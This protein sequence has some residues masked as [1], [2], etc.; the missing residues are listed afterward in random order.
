[1]AVLTVIYTLL[2]CSLG[3]FYFTQKY[4][5]TAVPFLGASWELVCLPTG[6]S[7]WGA[8][9]TFAEGMDRGTEGCTGQFTS[10]TTW[11]SNPFIPMQTPNK[12][13][14]GGLR[15]SGQQKPGCG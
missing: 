15:V 12:A 1:M 8:A 4:I 2:C 9:E 5:R 7:G 6:Q 11:A 3:Y 13:L 14:L 10:E